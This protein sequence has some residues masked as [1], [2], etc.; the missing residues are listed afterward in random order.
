M[1]RMAVYQGLMH[2]EVNA[3]SKSTLYDAFEVGSFTIPRRDIR[4]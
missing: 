2:G 4:F 1:I 3:F